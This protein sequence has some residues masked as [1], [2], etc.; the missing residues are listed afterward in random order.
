MKLHLLT[1]TVIIA[2]T[3]CNGQTAAYK[4]AK[5]VQKAIE[6]A[7]HPGTMPTKNGGWT[8]DSQLSYASCSCG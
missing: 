6:E 8:M 5:K 2:F 4:E 3:A 1:F 7:P